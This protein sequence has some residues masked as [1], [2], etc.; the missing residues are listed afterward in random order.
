MRHA[1]ALSPLALAALGCVAASFGVLACGSSASNTTSGGE[2]A[3]PDVGMGGMRDGSSRADAST[4]DGAFTR[5]AGTSTKDA[6]TDTGVDAAGECS[7][8]IQDGMET[9]VD[10]GGATCDAA[11]DTCAVGKKCDS[12]ADCKVND[13]CDTRTHLCAPNQCTDGVKDGTETAVDCGGATCDAAGYTCPVG[14]SCVVNADCTSGGCDPKTQ[15]CA[16]NQCTDG[17]KDGTETDV[18]CGG[19][20]CDAAGD[21]CALGQKCLVDADCASKGCDA[22]TKSC[23]A[24]QCSDGVMNGQ[25]TGLDCGGLVCDALNDLCGIGV[26]CLT[27]ADC[28]NDGG[29]DKMTHQCDATQCNDGQKDGMETGVDCGG[30]VCD[31]AGD[32]CPVGTGCATNGDCASGNCCS[33]TCSLTVCPVAA[34][35]QPGQ[36]STINTTATPATGTAGATSLTLAS[37]SGFAIGQTLFVQQ[38]Q[39]TNAGQ[40]ELAVITNLAGTSATLDAPLENTYSTTAP[41]TAQAVVVPQFTTVDV[42]A[43]AVL[44]APAWNGSTGGVLVFQ[45]TGAVTVEGTVS[46]AGSGFRGFSHAATCLPGGPAPAG[47]ACGTMPINGFAGESIAGPAVE[48]TI[49]MN[50]LGMANANGGGGGTYGQ[51]CG[52]GGGGSYGTA[53]AVGPNGSLGVCL[54]D[55]LHG[56]GEAGLVVGSTD[57]ATSLLFGGAGGEGGPDEDGA[58]PGGGGNGGGTVMILAPTSSVAVTGAITVDGA[59]G[60]NGVVTDPVC[61]GGGCGMGGGGGGAGGSIRIVTTTATLGAGLVQATGETG[62]SCTCTGVASAGVGG[63][64]RIQVTAMNV[65]G[66]TTPTY[67]Q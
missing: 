45:A 8:G 50:E 16:P 14:E 27:N 46:M 53:G 67:V 35:F 52:E 5:D 19:A 61:K 1:R 28:A 51:D 48:S 26:G 12:N 3:S 40:W 55:S 58:F 7:D 23:V 31:G 6:R 60:G 10:C 21:T 4:G 49:A 2:D 63:A 43:T 41:N 24:T 18:D 66:T 29:C 30:M 62:G 17:I 22:T 64:G 59:T 25:E 32:T 65:I 34:A 37:A 15:M 11:G 56:G 20:T 44:T 39:G 9:D 42:P 13:G 57:L 38:V 36:Q 47:N 33:D 54:A